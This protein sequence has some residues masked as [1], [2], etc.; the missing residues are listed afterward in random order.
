MRGGLPAAKTRARTHPPWG[1][2]LGDTGLELPQG[3]NQ[4]AVG[5]RYFGV[6]PWWVLVAMLDGF[7]ARERL[8][9]LAR[10]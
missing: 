7:G 3:L 5:V 10:R 6:A 2:V 4:D 9:S 8:P 1:G